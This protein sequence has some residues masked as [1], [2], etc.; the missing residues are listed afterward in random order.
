LTIKEV[1]HVSETVLNV[2]F[3]PWNHPRGAK[4]LV[5][6]IVSGLLTRVTYK[7]LGSAGL[8]RPAD[9]VQQLDAIVLLL[10]LPDT[11]QRG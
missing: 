1:T 3:A 10:E 4:E 7:E 2:F 9:S 6:C 11:R 8:V 5:A